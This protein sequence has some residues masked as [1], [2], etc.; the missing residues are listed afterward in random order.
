MHSFHQAARSPVPVT[1]PASFLWQ[2]GMD[3][4][5]MEQGWEA[6]QSV[7]M[8]WADPG[9]TLPSSAGRGEKTQ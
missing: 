1:A 2:Q 4:K 6:E 7:L 5:V 8:A 9:W 3:V